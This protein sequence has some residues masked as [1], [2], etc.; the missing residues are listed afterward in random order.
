MTFNINRT[1]FLAYMILCC[2]AI[3]IAQQTK[4]SSLTNNLRVGDS[5]RYD[6]VDIEKLCITGYDEATWDFSSLKY[7]GQEREVFFCSDDSAKVRMIGQDE[8]LDFKQTA[9]DLYLS[10]IQTA[11][12]KIDFG[13]TFE[14]LRYPFIANDSLVCNIEGHG[15]YSS[16]I[17]FFLK[18]ISTA[19][20]MGIEKIILPDNES[21]SNTL[22]IKR[23]VHGDIIPLDDNTEVKPDADKLQLEFNSYD[24]YAQG[25]RYPIFKILLASLKNGEQ[26]IMQRRYACVANVESFKKLEDSENEKLRAGQQ[27]KET[28]ESKTS[29]SLINYQVAMSGKLLNIAYSLSSDSQ[30][31]FVLSNTSGMLL[32]S[33]NLYQQ[34][35]DGYEQAIDLGN[36]PRGEYVLYINV[37]DQKFSEKVSVE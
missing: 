5:I 34:A 27:G 19:K 9:A 14:Y 7:S 29:S 26:K 8:M 11:L 25:Y 6:L 32:K 23:S 36:L 10:G 4:L 17:N 22:L 28:Q 3:A 35:G 18:G 24:W 16:K 12:V 2:N 13:D 15:T 20:A 21:L 30:L 37:N 1:Q 31:R 33:V